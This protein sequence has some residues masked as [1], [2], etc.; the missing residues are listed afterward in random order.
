MPQ[1]EI[2]VILVTV[3]LLDLEFILM[4]ADKLTPA[5]GCAL[6]QGIELARW[7]IF[8]LLE[9]GESDTVDIKHF[10]DLCVRSS[11]VKVF[12]AAMDFNGFLHAFV[13]LPSPFLLLRSF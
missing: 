8:F 6:F 4:E 9:I 7:A 12:L 13:D 3:T 5:F 1:K 11:S 10:C 2:F